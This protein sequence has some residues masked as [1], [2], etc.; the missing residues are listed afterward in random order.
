V[1]VL[2]DVEMDCLS[3]SAWVMWEG[4]G[5]QM[6]PYYTVLVT[7]SQGDIQMFQCNDT[8]VC[9]VSNMTCGQHLNFTLTASDDHC[10]SAPSNMIS[11]ET[12]GYCDDLSK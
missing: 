9:V 11:T 1:P 4:P 12:G 7:D 3:D 8:D 2:K 5:Q 6:D 10:T